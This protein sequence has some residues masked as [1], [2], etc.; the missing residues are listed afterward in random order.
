MLVFPSK[1]H[2]PQNEMHPLRVFLV[3]QVYALKI[4]IRNF[5]DFYLIL[6][7]VFPS[8]GIM[9]GGGIM[10]PMFI[11]AHSYGKGLIFS[12]Y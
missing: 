3:L 4:K 12:V 1:A 10:A 2:K 8:K 9:G 11:S 6:M 7:L 5:D